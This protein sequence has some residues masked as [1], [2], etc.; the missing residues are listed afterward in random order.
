MMPY[1]SA[2]IYARGDFFTIYFK[3]IYFLQC[4]DQNN[5][6]QQGM[7]QK[8]GSSAAHACIHALM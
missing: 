1:D 6:M 8:S 7:D 3:A 2:S 5:E 4:S